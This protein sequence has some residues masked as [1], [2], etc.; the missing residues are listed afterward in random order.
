MSDDDYALWEA[1]QEAAVDIFAQSAPSDPKFL[2]TE[3]GPLLEPGVIMLYGAYGA[4]KTWAASLITSQFLSGGDDLNTYWLDLERQQHKAAERFAQ[5]GYKQDDEWGFISYRTSYIPGGPAAAHADL[6]VAD[7]VSP[8]LTA[9]KPGASTNDDGSATLL[10]AEF[11]APLRDKGATV[12][13]LAHQAKNDDGTTPV[14]SQRWGA[15]ADYV[16]HIKTGKPWSK[17]QAGYSSLICRKDR[18]GSFTVGDEIA[19]LVMV[20]GQ[21]ARFE[22]PS[23]TQEAGAG[24]ERARKITELVKSRPGI[25]RADAVA[26]L[27]EANPELGQRRSWYDSVV[28]VMHDGQVAERD[29]GLFTAA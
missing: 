12:I 4:G 27:M 6:Y 19:R 1:D 3:S 13:L 21:L 20:P 15:M 9:I 11:V 22:V 28:R 2:V 29:K 24:G 16:L 18:F 14:G 10:E 17:D 26:A 25:S 8:L 7:A 23:K 5:C